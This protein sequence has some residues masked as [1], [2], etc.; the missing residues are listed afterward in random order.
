MTAKILAGVALLAMFE[1][2]EIMRQIVQDAVN[3]AY[4][5]LTAV[6]SPHKIKLS[7]LS[8]RGQAGPTGVYLP[9]HGVLIHLAAPMPFLEAGSDAAEHL[10]VDDVFVRRRGLLRLLAD[11]T[12]RAALHV[13]ASQVAFALERTQMIIHAVRRTY[14]HELADLSQGGRVPALLD[15]LADVIQRLGLA[16]RETLHGRVTLLN[17][18]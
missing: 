5:N 8:S 14:A 17:K 6:H 16:F 2:V 15:G 10:D 7:D 12:E 3:G 1:D 9:G 13:L 4:R 11:E 18:C